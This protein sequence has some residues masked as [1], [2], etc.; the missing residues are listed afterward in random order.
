[1]AQNQYT[2]ERYRE[3][4]PAPASQNP[5]NPMGDPNDYYG[6]RG[7]AVSGWYNQ[8]LGRD[9]DEDG[10]RGYVNGNM[11]LADIENAIKGSSEAQAYSSRSTAAPAAAGGQDWSQ[12]PWDANR[13]RAYFQSRGVTP[14][15]TSPEYWASKWQEFGQKD[16]AYFLQR[17]S[18]ADE[19]GGGGGAMGGGGAN[20]G[21]P[22]AVSGFTSQVRDLIM[23][24][25]GTLN[26][27]FDANSDPNVQ[28]AMSGA[29]LES[30]RSQAALRNVLSERL[31]A[32]GGGR[33]DSGAVNQ[34]EQQSAERSAVGLGS[35][36]AQLVQREL[37]AR[38]EE[39]QNYMQQALASGDAET[40]RQI[41]LY[42]ANLDA[43]LRREGYGINL[44]MF[45]QGQNA[46]TV[47]AGA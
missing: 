30:D 20:P 14:N 34:A 8:Y 38:R 9:Y 36:R 29:R 40:A 31:F 21:Q 44:A 16:P 19:F 26:Q 46:A 23:K 41:Q 3:E 15:G 18:T 25:I 22:G 45:G 27:P 12:G 13:V 47:G 6:S 43:Q 2:Q 4:Y 11:S 28:Q 24:R 33:V 1:M 35:M 17:L 42:T 32:Q 5:Q 37:L 10:Y 7:R 39:L